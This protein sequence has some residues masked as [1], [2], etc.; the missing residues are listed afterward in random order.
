MVLGTGVDRTY[1]GLKADTLNLPLVRVREMSE[2]DKQNGWPFQAGEAEGKPSPITYLQPTQK[3]SGTHR[4]D[5]PQ[6]RVDG[7]ELVLEIANNKKHKFKG[8]RS[9]TR[10]GAGR[11]RNEQAPPR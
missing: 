11:S 7:S 8:N 6:G 4:S 1:H 3:G 9:E 5:I 10:R 2:A